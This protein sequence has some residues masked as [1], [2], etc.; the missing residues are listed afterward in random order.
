[1]EKKKSE[2]IQPQQNIKPLT[3]YQARPLS[4]SSP[5]I[6]NRFGQEVRTGAPMDGF[7]AFLNGGGRQAEKASDELSNCTGLT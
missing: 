4:L 5:S 6:Q 1:M 2:S 3:P 7:T